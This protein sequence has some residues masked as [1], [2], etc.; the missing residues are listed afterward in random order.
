M[1]SFLVN[2]NFT[3]ICLWLLI[4]L[5]STSEST[6][7]YKDNLRSK[8][9]TATECLDVAGNVGYII[10]LLNSELNK[11]YT[12]SENPRFSCRRFCEAI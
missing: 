1:S 7:D 3:L 10:P 5:N 6:G 4:N 12:V 8:H 9:V 2:M 11:C